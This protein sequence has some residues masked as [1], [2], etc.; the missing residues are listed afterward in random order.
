MLRRARLRAVAALVSIASLAYAVP[1][2]AAYFVLDPGREAT[3]V[4]LG[5]ISF[6]TTVGGIQFDHTCAVTLNGTLAPDFVTSAGSAGGTLNSSTIGSCA[7]T[8]LGSLTVTPLFRS[9]TAWAITYTTF[10]GTLPSPNLVRFTIEGAQLLI[11]LPGIGTAC[12][13]STDIPIAMKYS[14]ASPNT[15]GLVRTLANSLGTLTT[16]SGTCGSS[17]SING[18]FSFAPRQTLSYDTAGPRA[19][20]TD[21]EWAQPGSRNVTIN[22]IGNVGFSVIQYDFIGPDRGHFS[23]PEES[24]K[25]CFVGLI[26]PKRDSCGESITFGGITTPNVNYY[27]LISVTVQGNGG[28]SYVAYGNLRG[29]G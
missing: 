11:D 10:T 1:A 8:G 25:N 27:A 22:N 24:R 7:R 14:A 15:S 17:V 9:P 23:A 19:R 21:F 16:L 13:Y 18:G 12:L 2:S 6:R 29:T 20:V 28:I 3:A 5:L 26:I 4:S